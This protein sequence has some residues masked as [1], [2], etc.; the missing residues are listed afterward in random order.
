ME[1]LARRLR[2][3]GRSILDL[4][5]RLVTGEPWPLSESYGTEPEADWGPREVLAHIDEMLPYWTE[6]LGIVLAGD[7]ATAVPFG[8]VATDPSRLA[9][10]GAERQRPVADL[11][12]DIARGLDGVDQFLATLE[13][14]DGDRVGRHSTRGEISVRDSVERFLVSHLEDHVEQLRAILGRPA[15]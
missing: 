13:P 3:A 15:A 4:R 12:D 11:L 1:D 7:R 5:D 9:R 14:E 10:I 2:E 8:R 6:Q